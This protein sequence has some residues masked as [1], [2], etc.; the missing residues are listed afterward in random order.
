M[1]LLAPKDARVQHATRASEG[2]AYLLPSNSSVTGGSTPPRTNAGGR[3]LFSRRP[4]QGVL[5]SQRSTL[6]VL[7]PHIPMNITGQLSKNLQ[8]GEKADQEDASHPK[9]VQL[10]SIHLHPQGLTYGSS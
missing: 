2:D 4:I 7:F 8:R 10:S 1:H 3:V 9:L 6:D 5:F